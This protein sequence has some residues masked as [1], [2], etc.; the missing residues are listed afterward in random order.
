VP[1]GTG[2]GDVKAVLAELNAQGFKGVFSIE[3]E[4]QFTLA[5]LAAC[6]K[7]FN[8]TAKEIAAGKAK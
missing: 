6:V 2:K 3:Y 1:W 7:F 5:D 8:D 4:H